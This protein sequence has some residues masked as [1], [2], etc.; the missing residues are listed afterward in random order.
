MFKKIISFSLLLIFIIISGFGCKGPDKQ[1][2]QLLRPVTL[3][4]WTIYSDVDVLRQLAKKYEALH[5]YIKINIRQVRYDEFDNL[6]V[7]ALADDVS[8]DI[9]SLHVAWLNKYLNRLSPAPKY[10]KIVNVYTQKG[11]IGSENY[12]TE[13]K[14]NSLY[15]AKALKSLY[16]KTVYN[17]VV[18]DGQV[19]GYPLTID[20]MAVYYNKDLLDLSGIPETP[21]TWDEFIE[22]VKKIV[23][24]NA[25]D[26]IVQAGAGLGTANNIKHASD[27]LSIL[28]LQS[29]GNLIKNNRVVFADELDKLKTQA[30]IFQALNFYTNFAN[31][32]KEIYTWNS[33]MSLDLD[34]FARGRLAFYFGYSYDLAEIKKRAPDINFG[35]IKLP[36]LTPEK[37][38]NIASYWLEAVPLKSKNQNEAWDF[39][40]FISSPQNVEEYTKATY[41]PSP[42]RQHLV[43]QMEDEKLEPFASQILFA[44]N[45][46]TGKDIDKTKQVL[47][48]LIV[49]FIE[50]FSGSESDHYKY[51]SNLIINTARA[52]QQT[53]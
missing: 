50:P 14:V 15:P 36:Q 34:E 2:Q 16:V 42:Y 8:P 47:N 9:V 6:F 39:V 53:L 10:T 44:E 31:P 18:K 20:T 24:I 26:K 13:L 48:D 41:R 23:K 21:Q 52:I 46:Y 29:G 51:I 11:V 33:D 27:I 43:K 28:V 49:K 4:Y 19:Y 40:R 37:P 1:T 17:D 12:Q 25:N 38:V 5:P 35:V 22:A 7:N 32:A 30:P 3:N 45:W